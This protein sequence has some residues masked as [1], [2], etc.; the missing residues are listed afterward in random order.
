VSDHGLVAL[1]L[2]TR[3]FAK[4]HP[5][6]MQFMDWSFCVG[7]AA[8]VTAAS[9]IANSYQSNSMRDRLRAVLFDIGTQLYISAEIA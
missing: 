5:F 1:K 7:F 8:F 2:S 3:H 6:V 4:H 9:L